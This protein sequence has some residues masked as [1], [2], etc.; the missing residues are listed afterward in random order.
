MFAVVF[1]GQGSQSIGMATDFADKFPEARE[2]FEAADDAFGGP[3]SRWIA[4]GP[5]EKLRLTEITQPAILTASI[6]MYR[7]LETRLPAQPS[8]FAGHS[9]GEYSAL[10]AAGALEL[11]DAVALVR[12]RGAFMQEA[13]PPG[14]GA[15]LAVLG[16]ERS[17]VERECALVGGIVAPANYNSPVQTV[18]AGQA[19]AVQEAAELLKSAGAKKLVPL[20]VSAPFHCELMAPA[21]EQLTSVLADIPLSDAR[22]PVISNV[23]ARPYT[24][25]AVARERLREQVCAPVRWVESVERLVADGV[26]L[27]LE[28]GPGKVLSGLSAKIERSLKRSNLGDVDALDSAVAAAGEA[29]EA[30]R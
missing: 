8:F 25:A 1:P 6:A 12:Q 13:V 7:V 9:L 11:G 23:T 2:V 24:E 19:G 15:M 22:V 4:E 28:V 29:E 27:Q 21:M 18:I 3:L 30:G 14:E 10:V 20:E 5:E 16:L 26:A 17:Q